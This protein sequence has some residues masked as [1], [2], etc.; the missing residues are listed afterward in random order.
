MYIYSPYSG[1]TH[2]NVREGI[3][4]LSCNVSLPIDYDYNAE[5]EKG[6]FG[7]GWVQEEGNILPLEIRR[8]ANVT[9]RCSLRPAQPPLLLE[10][11]CIKYIEHVTPGDEPLHQP[12]PTTLSLRERSGLQLSPAEGRRAGVGR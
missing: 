2:C 9:F 1:H 10:P 8:R 3:Y 7:R 6:G 12:V 11:P 4:S 5:M